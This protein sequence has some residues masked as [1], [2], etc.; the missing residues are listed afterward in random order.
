M[1]IHILSAVAV[2]IAG[3]AFHIT[4]TEWCLLVG[5]MGLVITAEIINTAIEN[6][7]N[8]VSPEINPLAGKAKD[9]AAGAVLIAAI[10]AAVIGSI[11]FLPYLLTLAELHKV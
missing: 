6:L 4:R 2:V 8:L 10:T 7:T 5:S 9:L 1:R 11:V 3:F